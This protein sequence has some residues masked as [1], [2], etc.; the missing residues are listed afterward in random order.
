MTFPAL[1]ATLVATEQMGH[2]GKTSRWGVSVAAVAA[3]LVLALLLPGPAAASV[4]KLTGSPKAEHPDIAVDDS[5]VSH[6]VWLQHG[7]TI[8]SDDVVYCRVPRGA[9]ACALTHHFGLGGIAHPPKVNLMPNGELVI[10]VERYGEDAAHTDADSKM[11]AITSNNGGAS[12]SQPVVLANLAGTIWGWVDSGGGEVEPG[13]GNFDLSLVGN[14]GGCN[15]GVHYTDAPLGDLTMG[16]ALLTGDCNKSFSPSV[17]FLDPTTPIAAYSDLDH[18]FYRRYDG[19]GDYNATAN[20]GPQRPA[21]FAA[22]E[23]RLAG[24]PRG[25]FLM[26]AGAGH[27]SGYSVRRYDGQS[28]SFGKPTKV[29]G[30]GSSTNSRDF[31]EDAT[32]TV[33]AVFDKQDHD[34]NWQIF[35]ATMPPGQGMAA[36][37]EAEPQ[38]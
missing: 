33:H 19:S 14:S 2:M 8:T 18:T 6:V 15:Q 4:Y 5:G 24:G 1:G 36:G 11:Y 25:V 21:P 13:P 20:W 27:P 26:Y 9:S 34:S 37:E 17:A 29:T 7:S 23:P 10:A 12:W 16:A 38:Q 28:N 31:L 32:G 22:G 30:K 35:H 3:T